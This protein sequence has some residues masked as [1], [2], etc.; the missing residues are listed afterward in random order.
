MENSKLSKNQFLLNYRKDIA[1]QF[2][3]DGILEK[4]FNIIKETD[5]WCVE[6][7][8][9]DGKFCSNT[10]NLIK[11][12][13]W[14]GV[15][16]EGDSQRIKSINK[17][18]DTNNK[19]YAV[20]KYVNFEGENTLDLILSKI[21]IPQNFDLLSID[22]D[23]NDYH[24]WDSLK[25]YLPKVVI[26]EFNPLIPNDIEFVQPKDMKVMQGNSILS[27]TKL[28]K[29]KGYDLVCI[30]S[31]NAI[32]VYNK[33]F[34]LFGIED[35]SIDELKHYKAPLQVF[36]LY[37]GTIVFHG[38]QGLHF[39]RFPVDF[40]KKFQV[41]P[42]FIRKANLPWTKNSKNLLLKILYFFYTLVKYNRKISREKEIAKKYCWSWIEDY[43]YY[44]K[45]KLY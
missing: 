42:A 20:N 40:N 28:A 6:F 24:I 30:N 17:T 23:G 14:T 13:N 1:S 5:K 32:Y 26:I 38:V 15:L 36:Q 41:L 2:G 21:P 39:Y 31:T 12:K 4:I 45:N 27:M 3:E 10:Y 43:S 18:Y 37:D 8:A 34:N 16:I 19:V 22:I 11:N 25:N 7:G 35:N 44:N 29:E 9:W 33:Y